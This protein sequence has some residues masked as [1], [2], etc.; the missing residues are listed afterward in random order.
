MCVCVCVCVCEHLTV[1]T[2][3]VSST[4]LISEF[5]HTETNGGVRANQTGRF[6]EAIKKELPLFMHVF[7][8]FDAEKP[9][10]S[11]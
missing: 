1:R 11:L 8:C 5:S 7:N 10:Y 4:A 2:M 6:T 9:N 3:F